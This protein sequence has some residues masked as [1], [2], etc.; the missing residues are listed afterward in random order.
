[1]FDDGNMKDDVK[2]PEGDVGDKIEKL[3]RTEEK[4]TSKSLRGLSRLMRTTVLTRV[5]CYR[6]YLDGR[7]GRHRGQGSS[8]WLDVPSTSSFLY[9]FRQEPWN[10]QNFRFL[11]SLCFPKQERIGFGELSTK[12]R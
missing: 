12:L 9:G 8:P 5:R 3:F 1:M 11:G 6:S 10:S 2:K 7:G 4:D